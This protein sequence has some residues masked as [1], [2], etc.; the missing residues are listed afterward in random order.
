MKKVL[1]LLGK[2]SITL[3]ILYYLFS[4]IGWSKIVRVMLSADIRYLLIALSLAM[5]VRYLNAVQT[6]VL[7]AHQG[8]LLPTAQV[9][10]INL[11]STFYTLFIPGDMGGGVVKWYKFSRVDGK[12]AQAFSV[13]LVAWLLP[14]F[15]IIM[16]GLIALAIKNPFSKTNLNMW[17]YSLLSLLLLVAIFIFNKSASALVDK[18]IMS[19]LFAIAPSRIEEKLRKVWESLKS[20]QKLPLFKVLSI[21]V[22]IVIIELTGITAHY[23]LG[24]SIKLRL[25]IFVFAWVRAVSILIQMLPISIAGL[26]L[27]EGAVIFLLDKYNVPYADALVFSLLVFGV[28]VVISLIG[29]LFEIREMLTNKLSY[30]QKNKYE[31]K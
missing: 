6:Q 5:L 29:G 27:R 21:L 12:R 11:I 22:T 30:C 4:K 15:A 2:L 7:L 20:F 3:G 28:Y 1:V 9:F 24:L 17:I 31:A 10:K 8:I 23:I 26:G 18:Y 25:S 13:I 14:V 19:P 16:D